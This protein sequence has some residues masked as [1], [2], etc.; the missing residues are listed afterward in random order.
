[1]LSHRIRE[2]MRP[3]GA[4][5]LG[6]KGKIVEADETYYGQIEKPLPKPKPEPGHKPRGPAFSAPSLRWFGAAARPHVPGAVADKATVDKIVTERRHRGSRLHT[7]ESKIY[8]DVPGH[9]ASHETV[10]AQRV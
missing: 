2:A 1:M 6:G 7:D 10:K 4:E 8:W 5:R 3:A 9:F